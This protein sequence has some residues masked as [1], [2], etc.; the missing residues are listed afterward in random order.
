[1]VEAYQ[2]NFEAGNKEGREVAIVGWSR[3][4]NSSDDF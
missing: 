1:M 2:R 4:M 3:G